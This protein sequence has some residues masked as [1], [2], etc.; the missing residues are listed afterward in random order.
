MQIENVYF[1]RRAGLVP[2]AVQLGVPGV[3]F[4]LG[5]LGRGRLGALRV[6]RP[7]G[8]GRRA[9][10]DR[11]RLLHRLRRLRQFRP[12]LPSAPAAQSSHVLRLPRPSHYHG[13]DQLPDGRAPAPAQPDYDDP[14][15][16]QRSGIFLVIFLHFIDI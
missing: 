1:D 8:L 11:D 12:V 15:L 5:A 7:L 2:V 10:L 4:A 9:R 6:C 13:H 16:W 3:R 14:V